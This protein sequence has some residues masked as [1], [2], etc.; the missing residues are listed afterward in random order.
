MN[1]TKLPSPPSTRSGWPWEA[2]HSSPPNL[3]V[4]PMAYP[5]ISI[6]TPSCNQA[7]YLEET[8]RSVL[9]QGYPNLEYFVIDGGST[10]GSIDIIRKYEAWITGWVSEADRG[11]SHAINKGFQRCTGDLITFQNSDDYYL[12]GAFEDAA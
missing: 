11:Q 6:V 4:P 10:D 1:L 2:S 5:R 8:I 7:A 12:P 9:L 3:A